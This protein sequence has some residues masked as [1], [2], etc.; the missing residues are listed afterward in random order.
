MTNLIRVDPGGIVIRFQIILEI[1]KPK[2][3]TQR[4]LVFNV[5]FQEKLFADLGQ[6]HTQIGHLSK[7]QQQQPS[8]EFSTRQQQNKSL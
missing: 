7:M 3:V 8:A 6:G 5:R 1:E 2:N 4:D